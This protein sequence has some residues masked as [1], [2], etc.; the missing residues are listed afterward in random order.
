MRK[1]KRTDG[2]RTHGLLVLGI[3]KRAVR[4]SCAPRVLRM[5]KEGYVLR[6]TF[7]NDIELLLVIRMR[8]LGKD[9]AS[10]RVT[11]AYGPSGPLP[12]GVGDTL[13][14]DLMG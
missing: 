13:L 2:V 12:L 7:N 4:V 1:S 14:V 6:H 8:K 9:R 11:R 10:L 5:L 3:G